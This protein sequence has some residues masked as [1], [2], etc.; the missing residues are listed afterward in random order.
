MTDDPSSVTLPS[1]PRRSQR[2]ALT[3]E[4]EL[5]RTRTTRHSVTVRD[6]S[7]HGCCINLIDRVSLDEIIWIKLPG[8][9]SLEAYVCWTKGFVAGVEFTKPL[10]PAVF[11][12]VRNQHTDD[13]K[14]L[15]DASGQAR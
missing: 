8:I 14:T 10:H 2:V 13:L 12:L 11:D 6:L 4:I 9:E 3:A 7:C 1:K 15:R 5:R